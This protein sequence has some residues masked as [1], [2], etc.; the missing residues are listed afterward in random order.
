[1]KKPPE[2]SFPLPVRIW[3]GLKDPIG[4]LTY[5]EAELGDVVALRQG[6]S[7]ALF[8][9]DHIRHV[10]QENA[11][12]YEKGV[13]YRAA[14]GPIMGNGIFTSEGAFW[15]RHRRLAQN[16]FQRAH[17][18]SF[19][20]CITDCLKDLLDDWGRRSSRGEAIDIRRDLVLAT[21]RMTVRN[22]FSTE[23]DMTTLAPAVVEVSEQIH[24]GAQFVPFHLPKWVQTPARRRFAAGMKVIDDFAYR[25]IADRRKI[26]AGNRDFV[27]LM[28]DA[29]DEETGEGMSDQQLRDELVTMLIAGHD[30]VTDA[31]VWT[32]VLLAQHPE[33]AARLREEIRRVAGDGWPSV[34]ALKELEL[35]GRV[36]HETLR[37]YPPGWVFARTAL[38]DDEIGGYT[39]PAG[40]IVAISPFVMQRSRRY[41]DDPLRFDPDRF[42]PEKAAGRP[43]FIYFPFGG[44]QR[45]CIGQG[46]AMIELPLLL[47]GILRRF[48]FEI[49]DAASIK[50]SPRI[51]LRPG[52]VVR[53]RL[54]PT[55]TSQARSTA[56]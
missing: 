32:M 41:W 40:S 47:V 39:I 4:Y 2:P 52:Q 10:L 31:A 46:L 36:I 43:R 19:A 3:R 15:L 29:R 30:T 33:C 11:K 28:M 7:Y 49:D 35:L 17:V 8:H 5:A 18:A 25:V 14:L 1:V 38:T 37:L 21:L 34:E 24:F 45:Q 50:P 9:P 51:S 42:L 26:A 54:H 53:A 55:R 13:K 20:D 6:R 44:G 23:P 48:E 27:S 16:A 56:G 22:L 12:N